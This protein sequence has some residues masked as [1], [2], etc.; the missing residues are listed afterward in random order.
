MPITGHNFLGFMPSRIGEK[1][2]RAVDPSLDKEIEPV[3]YEATATEIDET[4]KRA[5]AAFIEYRGRSGRQR[6]QFL[7]SMATK[8]E[9]FGE[10]LIQRAAFETALPIARLT[11]ERG[12]TTGQLRM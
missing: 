9:E 11:G 7:R 5:E 1:T 4:M 3:F 12:R 6:A 10:E 8:I 2:F